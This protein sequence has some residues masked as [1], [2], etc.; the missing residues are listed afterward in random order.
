MRNGIHCVIVNDETGRIVRVVGEVDM[1]TAPILEE[2]LSRLDGSATTIDLTGVSFIDSTGLHVLVQTHK[3]VVGN[4]GT[5]QVT[6]MQPSVRQVFDVTGLD[7][8]FEIG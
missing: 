6:G 5:L 2:T 8:Y 4:G 3:R 7:R 1:S